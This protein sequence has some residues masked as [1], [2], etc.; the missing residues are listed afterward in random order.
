MKTYTIILIFISNLLFSRNNENT[1]IF[2]TTK[3]AQPPYNN[4]VSYDTII[5][6]GILNLQFYRDNFKTPF[7]F[8]NEFINTKYKNKTVIVWGNKT[9]R[10]DLNLNYKYTFTY[11]SLSRV[12]SYSYSGCMICSRAAFDIRVS[13]D[14]LN[15]PL[16]LS[17]LNFTNKSNSIQFIFKYDTKMNI[18]NISL[19]VNDKL[20]YEILKLD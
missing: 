4:Q 2:K 3:F 7:D 5:H 15:R 11:D 10:K 19:Y 17:Y 18:I 8:P 1:L 14:S 9:S 13:Y 16:N 20:E 6:K 12:I